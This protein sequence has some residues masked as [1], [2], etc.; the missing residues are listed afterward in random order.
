MTSQGNL[1]THALQKLAKASI[2][3]GKY[4]RKP[5]D[6]GLSKP[7]GAGRRR[8]GGELA[9]VE[10]D[11]DDFRPIRVRGKALVGG[12]EEF[13]PIKVRGKRAAIYGPGI[14]PNSGY[15]VAAA[16]KRK[17]RKGKGLVGGGPVGGGLESDD[18]R[19]FGG[20]ATSEGAYHNPWVQF[21]R[22]WA[23]EHGLSYHDALLGHGAQISADYKGA[24]KKD[25]LP[26]VRK[27]RAHPAASKLKKKELI[28]ELVKLGYPHAELRSLLKIEL[29]KILSEEVRHM[30]KEAK[31]GKRSKKGRGLVPDGDMDEEE[32]P[33]AL[34]AGALVGGK[35]KK[36]PKKFT[37]IKYGRQCSKK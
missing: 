2:E 33:I 34:S 29:K 27:A 22:A 8:R 20:Y 32:L 37:K 15:S 25:Y 11:T 19:G 35:K 3:S 31:K 4:A 24:E 7:E 16:G 6:A 18:D 14:T 5:L 12:G 26:K 1:G 10:V 13:V 17:S 28:E 23:D 36:G 9:A 30:K 21:V